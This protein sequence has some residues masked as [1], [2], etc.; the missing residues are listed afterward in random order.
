M[1]TETPKNQDARPAD[2]KAGALSEAFAI[3][4]A[5]PQHSPSTLEARAEGRAEALNILLQLDPEEGLDA[6]IDNRPSGCDSGEWTAFWDEA[7]LRDFLKVDDATYAAFDV[8][9]AAAWLPKGDRPAAADA[10]VLSIEDAEI[11]DMAAR[12]YTAGDYIFE[13]AELLAYVR[14]ILAASVRPAA[15]MAEALPDAEAELLNMLGR[16]HPM[17]TMRNDA[18]AEERLS[19]AYCRQQPWPVPDQACIVWRADLMR[20]ANDLTHKQAFFDMHRDRTAAMGAGD[21][22]A[23][24]R[25]VMDMD[26]PITGN[27]SHEELVEFWEYEK[28]QGRGEADTRLAA[29]RAIANA[30]RAAA[31]GAAVLPDV[32]LSDEM[33]RAFGNRHDPHLDGVSITALSCIVDD[34]RSIEHAPVPEK[35]GA[36]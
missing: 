35:G 17:L 32:V 1:N 5:G 26:C 7:K 10:A 34:A 15:V 31:S 14:R 27:P 13:G 2:E 6:Y 22:L 24:L 11:L 33:V 36:A 20:M 23:S 9:E 28:T 30:D 21:L 3:A 8:A 12:S 4:T 16:E 19:R 25:A 18:L 29:L